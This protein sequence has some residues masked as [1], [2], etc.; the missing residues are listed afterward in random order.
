M[1]TITSRRL[2][3]M[4]N[5]SV[6]WNSTGTQPMGDF[7]FRN[8]WSAGS[9]FLTVANSG[10]VRLL[11]S[12]NRIY[13]E[14]PKGAYQG[15]LE[16]VVRHGNQMNK[17]TITILDVTE[18]LD[19]GNIGVGTSNNVSQVM[20]VGYVFKEDESGNPII[21]GAEPNNDEDDD[22]EDDNDEDDEN[23]DDEED[24]DENENDDDNSTEIRTERP[25][26]NPPRDTGRETPRETPRPAIEDDDYIII[27]DLDVPLAFFEE[28]NEASPIIDD[29]Q[30]ETEEETDAEVLVIIDEL[31]VPLSDMPQ[32]GLADVASGLAAT[33]LVCLTVAACALHFI[34]RRAK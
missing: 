21:I 31:P 16:I 32:T 6:I 5:S 34:C 26:G 24:D 30:T 25:Q 4:E 7:D 13:L 11:S 20:I 27:E 8:D 2:K 28:E 18:E 22:D 10:G 1:E 33:A 12:G 23:E 9:G 29:F 3:Y 15:T 14:V 17:T 19:L